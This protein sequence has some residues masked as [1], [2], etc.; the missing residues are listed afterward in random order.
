MNWRK[1]LCI[2]I[3]SGTVVTAV[4]GC[5]QV[6]ST[7]SAATQTPDVTRTDNTPRQ[8][9]PNGFS[10]NGTRPLMPSGNFT[11]E[12]PS[13][14]A[15]DLASAAANLGISESQLREALG[16]TQQ[17]FPDLAAAAEKLGITEDALLEA[18]GF[19]GNNMMPGR[20]QQSMPA[21]AGQ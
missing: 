19:S 14:P 15:M 16:D 21:P 10:D 11:G 17:G 9:S 1:L 18:L 3:L 13:A 5:N 7:V 4:F 2:V 6:E 20:P 8:M 12:R